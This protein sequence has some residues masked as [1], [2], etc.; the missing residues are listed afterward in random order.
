MNILLAIHHHLCEKVI[1]IFPQ[2]NGH[3]IINR[4]VTRT[5]VSDIINLG[6][7]IVNRAPLKELDKIFLEQLQETTNSPN[8][9]N[10]QQA[11]YVELCP[12]L[13]KEGK[14]QRKNCRS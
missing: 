13:Q 1:Y 8:S 4:T 12:G 11:Q 5:T 10:S 3:R 7:C 14:K 6:Q 2:Y 9:Q